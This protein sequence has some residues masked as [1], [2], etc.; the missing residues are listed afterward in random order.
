[1]TFVVSRHRFKPFSR[2]RHPSTAT[3]GP[4]EHGRD[5]IG[6]D[7]RSRGVANGESCARGFRC[8]RDAA[9]RIRVATNPEQPIGRD[10]RPTVR[11]PK[12]GRSAMRLV[13]VGDPHDP[14]AFAA[15]CAATSNRP[16]RNSRGVRSAAPAVA[17][18]DAVPITA[19]R[20]GTRRAAVLA[21]ASPAIAW[22]AAQSGC[23]IDQEMIMTKLSK[24]SF[25][26]LAAFVFG[27]A[28][29]GTASSAADACQTCWN[30]YNKCEQLGGLNCEIR[31]ND[32]LRRNNCP[33]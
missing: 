26:A 10:D 12:R 24:R 16:I 3:H 14:A 6:C 8:A 33:L 22:A 11:R 32:C 18:P 30:T 1:M 7:A 4:G 15:C 17:F 31:L 19:V 13:G 21:S 20:P 9:R 27:C 2:R 25:A 29:A 28:L 5:A 23:L